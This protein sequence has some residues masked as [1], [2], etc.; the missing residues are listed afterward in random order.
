MKKLLGII[1][2][3]LL[4]STSANAGLFSKNEF[5]FSRCYTE[6]YNNHDDW[7]ADS[8][9]LRWDWEINLKNKTATRLAQLQVDDKELSIDQ[10]QI[11]AVTK[12]FIK[13]NTISD[14]S[15]IFYRKTGEIQIVGWSGKSTMKC[16]IFD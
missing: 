11:V 16:E 8:L 7:L 13:T 10:F 9:F 3:G 4:L 14:T 1:V 2:L 12:E 6:S 5:K 15:Y